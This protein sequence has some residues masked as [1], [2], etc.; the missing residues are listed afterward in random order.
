MVP[1]SKWIRGIAPE[2]PV[3]AAARVVWEARLATFLGFLP[4]A[5]KHHEQD[6]EYVHQLRVSSRRLGA[7]IEFF[8][9]V[10]PPN[11][12]KRLK[13]KIRHVRRAAGDA[14]DLDVLLEHLSDYVGSEEAKKEKNLIRKFLRKRR[15]EAQTDIVD[16][17]RRVRA[18]L[19][20]KEMSHFTPKIKWR[21]CTPHDLEPTFGEFARQRLRTVVEEIADHAGQGWPDVETL[22]AFRIVLKHLRYTMELAEAAFP[23][24]FKKE[25]YPAVEHLQEPLGRI[26]D[27]ATAERCFGDWSAQATEDDLRDALTACQQRATDTLATTWQEFDDYWHREGGQQLVVELVNYAGADVAVD[28]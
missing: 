12:T 22:H 10:L 3:S 14:R 17:E 8:R 15:S 18:G 23:A 4:L 26:N 9:E 19:S 20:P 7:A 6:V 11:R 25:L 24:S 16:V 5:A 21:K 27:L 13:K 1:K 28:G 2:Q